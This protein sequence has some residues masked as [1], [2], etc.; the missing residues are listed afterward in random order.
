MAN[1]INENYELIEDMPLENAE[2]A[3]E[4]MEEEHNELLEPADEKSVETVEE[5]KEIRKPS[6]KTPKPVEK[7]LDKKKLLVGALVAFLLLALVASI[8][9]PLIKS[10]K[11]KE[12]PVVMAV[13]G[14]PVYLDSFSYYLYAT[15]KDYTSYGY[16]I[17]YFKDESTFEFIKSYVVDY[18]KQQYVFLNWAKACGIE[19]SDTI[20]QKC[21]SQ[22]D[23]LKASCESE[24]AYLALLQESHLTEDLYFEFLCNDALLSTFNAYL[25]SEISPVY[26]SAEEAANIAEENGIYGA[27]HILVSP[28]PEKPDEE[29][30]KL[31]EELLNRIQNG[32]DF[33]TLMF[34]YTD[35]SGIESYPNGYTFGE[36]DM[37]DE[38]FEATE[39]LQMG[40]ISG[41]VK[42]QYGYHIIKRVEPTPQEAANKLIQERSVE[43][44][45]ILLQNAIVQ[46]TDVYTSL[47]FSD[48]FED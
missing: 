26:V 15:I 7:K 23:E 4:V 41:I 32:E 33:D 25:Y 13:D 6:G 12:R 27:K 11:N 36:G 48:F 1:E 30:L 9:S 46:T 22:M 10:K 29:C 21:R 28:N 8:V 19:I 44:Y 17:S 2:N 18:V 45:E 14:T 34:E 24:E 35:D 20:K 43:L 37:V 40:E 31:A 3:A 42:S 47:K 39:A 5:K 16:D 38:F